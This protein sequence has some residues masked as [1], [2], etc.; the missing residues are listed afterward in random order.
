[1]EDNN[2]STF[3][4][5]YV[6]NCQ[7][8]YCKLETYWENL[9][10]LWWNYW[11]CSSF[12]YFYGNSSKWCNYSIGVDSSSINVDFRY[13]Q[14][15]L[16]WSVRNPIIM[17]RPAYNYTVAETHRGKIYI[18]YLGVE[19]KGYSTLFSAI[20]GFFTITAIVGFPL[21]FLFWEQQLF[22]W[23]SSSCFLLLLLQ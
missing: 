19:I 16:P 23:N 17:A 6:A 20:L 1:M 15:V 13:D 4:R 3:Y 11:R 9:F 7:K 21:S 14:S 12:D 22:Y 2:V 5:Y 8:C 10:N 18:P